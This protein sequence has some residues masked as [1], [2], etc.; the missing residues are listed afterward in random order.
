M[1]Q[2]TPLSTPWLIADP[3]IERLLNEYDT[4]HMEEDLI[5]RGLPPREVGRRR[6]EFSVSVG[7]ASGLLMNLLIRESHS[8]SILEL[9]TSNGYSTIWLAEGAR[10]TGGRVVTVD[11]MAHKHATARASLER[12]GLLDVVDFHLGDACEFLASTTATFDFVLL[13]VWKESYIPCIE[14]LVPRLQ[15]GATIVADNMSEP[16]FVRVAALRYLAHLRRWPDL[17]TIQLAVG[18]GL[19]ISRYRLNC[20]VSAC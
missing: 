17:Q 7:R 19:A 16:E 9:G 10:A 3:D 20:S 14:A 6:D 12:A 8:E 11:V 4:Q 2:I 18:S 13:D 5:M 15:P 1:P